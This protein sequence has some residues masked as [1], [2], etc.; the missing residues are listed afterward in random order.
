MV[1]TKEIDLDK[2]RKKIDEIDEGIQQLIVERATIVQKV[3]EI[4]RQSTETP[5]FYRPE[6]EAAILKQVMHRPCSPLSKEEMAKIFRI[7][8]SA[9]LALQQPLKI[10]FL[11]PLGTFSH[12]ASLKHFG[13]S[14]ILIPSTTIHEVFGNVISKTASFG[15][16]PIENS[17]GGVVNATMNAFIESPLQICGEVSLPIHQQLLVSSDNENRIERIYSHEQSLRQCHKWLNQHYPDIEQVAVSSNAYAAKLVMKDKSAA[18][19]AGEI[20]A[21]KYNLKVIAKNIEDDPNNN[22]RFLIIC[23][24]SPPPSGDDRTSLLLS[25]SNSPGALENLLKPFSQNNINLTLITSQPSLQ[26]R[27]RY[28]FFL[29]IDV[30]QEDEAFK[31]ALNELDAGCVSIKI[32]GSYPK[33][34]LA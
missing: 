34:V 25:I 5:I 26:E 24:Q 6:R 16:V 3:G 33:A 23:H 32:L 11:G 13:D 20:A 14:I 28:L 7:I 17:I 19:I 31:A 22:T 1:D 2:V 29:D 18:A 8:M 10:A 12:A 27:N 9:C 4:K 21:E 30:H 15:V